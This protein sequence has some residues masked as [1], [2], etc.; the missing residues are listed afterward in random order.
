M[1]MVCRKTGAQKD[2]RKWESIEFTTDV[3]TLH[4][5]LCVMMVART[6]KSFCIFSP[7]LNHRA[8]Q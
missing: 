8:S 3:E 5:C 1:R 2:K 6:R 7:S 4:E